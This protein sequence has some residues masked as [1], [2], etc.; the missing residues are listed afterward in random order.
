[1]VKCQM[2]KAGDPTL[3]RPGLCADVDGQS[4]DDEAYGPF[5]CERQNFSQMLAADEALEW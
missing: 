3:V 5:L 4:G 2:V 1:M